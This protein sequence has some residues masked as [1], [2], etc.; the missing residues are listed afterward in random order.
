M[1]I[2]TPQGAMRLARLDVYLGWEIASRSPGRSV[3]LPNDH[4][5]SSAAL[6]SPFTARASR[7]TPV[8]RIKAPS[9]QRLGQRFP[10]SSRKKKFPVGE[11]VVTGPDGLT[12]FDQVGSRYPHGGPC[13]STSGLPRKQAP[14]LSAAMYAVCH[15]RT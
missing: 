5:V 4:R 1:V 8:K 11:C 10:P 12:D 3:T 9:A 6:L 14:T 2:V 13:R 7:L 15:E